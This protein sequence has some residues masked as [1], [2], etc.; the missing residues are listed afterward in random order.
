YRTTGI[1]TSFD[2]ELQL[3]ANRRRSRTLTWG[4]TKKRQDRPLETVCPGARWRLGNVSDN[5][6]ARDLGNAVQPVVLAEC[7]QPLGLGGERA[8]G[9]LRLGLAMVNTVLVAA[10]ADL[11]SLR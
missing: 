9:G 7:Q 11:G 3:N 8:D 4:D 6:N 10:R 1:D 5:R 2:R